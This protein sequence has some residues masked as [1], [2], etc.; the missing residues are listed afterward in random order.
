MRKHAVKKLPYLLKYVPD[1]Y[2][3]PQI[4]DNA[5]P[6]NGRTVESVP[7]DCKSKK[8]VTELLII[9]LTH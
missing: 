1:Q 5:I 4:C 7:D 9:T 8:C 2:K 3:T 6:E